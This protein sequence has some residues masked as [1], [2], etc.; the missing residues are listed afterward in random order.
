MNAGLQK[1]ENIY[2]GNSPVYSPNDSL[3]EFAKKYAENPKHG[4]GLATK[5]K[6]PLSTKIKDIPILELAHAMLQQEDINLYN[7]YIKGN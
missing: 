5:L 4:Q 1:L 2:A 7:T 3:E 6:L